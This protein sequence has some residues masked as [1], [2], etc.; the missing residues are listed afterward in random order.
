M[1]EEKID[2]YQEQKKLV[3]ARLRTLSPD[4]KIMSGGDKP[5]SVREL[6]RH[7]ESD[8]PFGKDIIK[9]QIKMLNILANV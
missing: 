7:V 8:D 2:I 3:L 9:A 5:I 6:I 1:T 4:I